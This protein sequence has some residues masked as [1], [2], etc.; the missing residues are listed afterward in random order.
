MRRRQHPLRSRFRPLFPSLLVVVTSCGG[1]K[2]VATPVATAEEISSDR[3]T[4]P[5]A[6]AVP[7]AE[8]RRGLAALAL[9]V[10]DQVRDT[11]RDPLALIPSRARLVVQFR[12]RALHEGIKGFGDALAWVANKAEDGAPQTLSAM[13]AC[14]VAVSGLESLTYGS[15]GEGSA[16]IVLRGAKI[17]TPDVWRC[18]KT[19][20]VAA[21]HTPKF[22][23]ESTGGQTIFRDDEHEG[24]FVDDETIVLFHASW[25]NDVDGLLSGTDPKTVADG[26]LADVLTHVDATEPAWIAGMLFDDVRRDLAGSPVADAEKIWGALSLGDELALSLATETSSEE[27]ALTMKDGVRNDWDGVSGMASGMGIPKGITDSVEFRAT[28]TT[29]SLHVRATIADL[30]AVA[31][32]IS[33]MI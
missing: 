20:M 7:T 26:D 1:G 32:L 3:T 27:A 8:P 33:G 13:Q 15:E 17:G 12:P 25:E 10:A 14:D 23:I 24:R 31:A 28:G 30:E 21:G 18:I 16:V 22:S 11:P 19:E 4:S 29:A 6:A 9:D 2:D 5:A